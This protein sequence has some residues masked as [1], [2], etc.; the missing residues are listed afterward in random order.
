LARIAARWSGDRRG[1]IAVISAFM[2]V[3]VLFGLGIA[4]DYSLAATRQDKVNGIADSAALYAVTPNMLTL[5]STTVQTQTQAMMAAQ[6]NALGNVG[7]SLGNLNIAITDVATGTTVS[8]T[9]VVA[10]RA[11]SNNIFSGV[12]GLQN[13]P[14]SGTSTAKSALAPKIDFYLLLDTS[15]SMGIAATTSGIS[16]MVAHTSSQGGC[17]FAC[18]E[19]NPAADGL[20]NP[21][22]EDNYALARNLGVTLRIDLVNQAVQNL[23]SSAVTTQ[24]LNNT[25]YRAGIYTMDY[26][27]NTLYG[28]SANLSAA[29][30]A[31][32]NIQ[33]LQVYQNTWLTASNA[34]NDEDSNLDQALSTL[35]T[36]MPNPGGGTNNTGD[37]PQEVLFIVSDG[38]VDEP[39]SGNRIVAPIN[40]MASWCASIKAR[41]TRIA[42][43]YLTYN[44]LPT[45][46]FYQQNVAWFQSSIATD[47]QNC[48]SP[49]LYFQVN[50]GGD[51]SAAMTTL[52]QKIVATARLT[53]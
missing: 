45:N 22:G 34:N 39:I 38:V 3:L 15:P 1:N 21:G 11:T 28:L 47:A 33:Q 19:S 49:G 18:H 41:G 25:T 46:A 50:T 36:A 40:T 31:A 16:T 27:V 51:I 52:F 26:S 6:M 29:A 42:F 30:T 12:L 5:N 24:Q 37:T 20:G 48:A 14:I 2:I 9:V 4:I 10:Y 7:Y 17:A 35:N 53:Q 23:M 44:P 13:L 8:R 43:L 32:S